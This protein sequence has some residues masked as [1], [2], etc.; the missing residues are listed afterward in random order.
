MSLSFIPNT[1]FP[2]S[3][4]LPPPFQSPTPPTN[5]FS[6]TPPGLQAP[7]DSIKDPNLKRRGSSL[8][9]LVGARWADSTTTKYRNGWKKWRM[10]CQI[11]PESPPRPA[12]PFYIC[13]YLNDLFLDKCKFGAYTYSIF[14]YSIGG[15]S[16]YTCLIEWTTNSY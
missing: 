12:S 10:W 15:T 2:F 6:R 16:R 14:E 3:G 4:I 7:S 8:P 5:S 1:H 9:A 11:H 13:L